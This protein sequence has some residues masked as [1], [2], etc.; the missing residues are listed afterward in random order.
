[1]VCRERSGVWISSTS[2]QP[3]VSIFAFGQVVERFDELL[4]DVRH[5]HAPRGVGATALYGTT[6]IRRDGSSLSDSLRPSQYLVVCCTA[7]ANRP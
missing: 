7:C 4:E 5:L 3:T 1:M 2:Q 6:V